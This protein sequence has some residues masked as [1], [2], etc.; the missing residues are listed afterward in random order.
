MPPREDGHG[1]E[2][3]ESLYRAAGRDPTSIPWAD[4]EPTPVLVRWLGEAR[5]TPGDASVV[6][7][8]LGDDAEALAAA[9]WRVTAFDISPA[10]IA[11]CRDRFPESRVDYQVQDLSDVPSSWHGAFDLVVEART[12]QSFPP[13]QQPQT[14]AWISDLVA[15]GGRLLVATIG[16]RGTPAENGPPWP[17]A[18]SD[19]AAFLEQG[20]E[21]R[22]VS[23]YPSPWDG[24]E[25]FELEYLKR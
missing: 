21:L 16:H 25:F 23:A 22:E 12:I 13:D 17:V 7:C 9:G 8:G 11:W 24:F 10:A 2:F 5:A 3:F 19:L 4:M 18:E 15:A 1:P 6:A 20:L 14:M